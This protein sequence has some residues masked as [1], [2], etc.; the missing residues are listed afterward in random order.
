MNAKI[1]KAIEWLKTRSWKRNV[2]FL[3]VFIPI[4]LQKFGISEEA[5][6][7]INQ[8]VSAATGNITDD[9][10]LATT[11]AGASFYLYGWIKRK[12]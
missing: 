11:I 2:G 1:N 7:W 4:I 5:I 9:G 3:V 6:G 8:L 12:K 10:T